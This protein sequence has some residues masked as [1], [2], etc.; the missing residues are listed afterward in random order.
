MERIKLN[1]FSLTYRKLED[2][3]KEKTPLIAQIVL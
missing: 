2:I 3:V 1:E